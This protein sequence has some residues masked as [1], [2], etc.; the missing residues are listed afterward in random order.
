MKIRA[1]VFAGI[2]L[3]AVCAVQAQAA[4][5]GGGSYAVVNNWA[6]PYVG[7]TLGF[8]DATSTFS[9]SP[10]PIGP[11]SL[12]GS[13]SQF[14]IGLIAGYNWQNGNQVFGLETD[15]DLPSGFDYF[16]TLRGR[17]GVVNGNWLYYGTAGLSFTSAG[18]SSGYYNYSGFSGI[19]YIVG[20]GAET[21]IN[22]RLAAGF[23][24]L[25]YGFMDDT[26]NFMGSTIT[27]SV[28]AFAVRGRITYQIGGF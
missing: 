2:A 5:L 4:D 14:G 19:G 10:T 28:D 25:Y 22:S 17:Y 27:T 12:S 20:A 15:I 13:G 24:A 26:Q 1:S 23:E 7:G 8:V 11:I 18:G 16:G 6:G 9:V 21:K 3:G